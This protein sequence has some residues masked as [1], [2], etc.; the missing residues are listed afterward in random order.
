MLRTAG[1]LIIF[2][3]SILFVAGLRLQVQAGGADECTKL[4]QELYGVNGGGGVIAALRRDSAD[5]ARFREKVKRDEEDL[6]GAR[7]QQATYFIE[8]GKTDAMLEWKLRSNTR[9]LDESRRTLAYYKNRENNDIRALNRIGL[10][11]SSIRGCRE[12]EHERPP[13]LSAGPR[14]DWNGAYVG[15]NGASTMSISGEANSLTAKMEWTQPGATHGVQGSDDTATCRVREY[16]A[17]CTTEGQY[18]DADKEITYKGSSELTLSGNK[19]TVVETIAS[20]VCDAKKVPDCEDL[21]YT[22]TVTKGAKFTTVFT[23]R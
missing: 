12:W 8:H 21:G 5:V 3:V 9:N 7:E 18:H 2:A 14:E 22:P 13:E 17:N 1:V 6:D 15:N 20:T 19:V 10:A 4:N 16:T 11:M 23:R